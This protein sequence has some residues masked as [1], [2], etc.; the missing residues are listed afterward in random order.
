DDAEIAGIYDGLDAD[1]PTRT[2]L[3]SRL[4][5]LQMPAG[6]CVVFQGT[7]LHRGGANRSAA[8]RLA[9]SNQYCEPWARTQENYFLAIP[10]Q[11]ARRFSPRLQ[12][13]LGYHIWPPFMGHVSA[14][15]PLKALSE[16]WVPPVLREL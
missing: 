8:P 13:L 10:P 16:D 14:L 6:A 3:E 9:F 15:H 2:D 12:T 4:V 5:P 11:V 7:L 1:L